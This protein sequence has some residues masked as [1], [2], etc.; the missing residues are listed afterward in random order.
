MY[1]AGLVLPS[2][3]LSWSFWSN[4]VSIQLL[5]TLLSYCRCNELPQS[6]LKQHQLIIL[7]FWRSEGCHE[8]HRAE[9]EESAGM[10]S[11]LE[12]PGENPFSCFLCLLEAACISRLTVLSHLK[13]EQWSIELLSCCIICFAASLLHVYRPCDYS[14]PTWNTQDPLIFKSAD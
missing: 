3:R 11:F 12:A 10:S 2:S 7:H 6:G 13:N 1:S 8:S 14:G 5:S 9:I 4:T